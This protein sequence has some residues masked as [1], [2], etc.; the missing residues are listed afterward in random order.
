MANITNLFPGGFT[1]P[2]P[3]HKE[4]PEQ[5]L[6]QAMEIAGMLAPEQIHMDGKIHR[7]SVTGKKKDDSG[8][9]VIYPDK[10]PAGAFGNWKDGT[11]QTWRADIGRDLTIQEEMAHKRRITEARKQQQEEQAKRREVA[12]DTSETIWNGATEA[13]NDHPYLKRK[14]IEAHGIRVTGDGR[15]IVPM[16]VDG[17]LSS[18]QY[19]DGDGGKKFQGG[20][21]TSGACFIVGDPSEKTLVIC[22]GFADAAII[23]QVTGLPALCAFSAHNMPA[24]AKYA[25]TLNPSLV[26]VA[27]ND[28][29]GTGQKYGKQAA[30][31]TNS[32]LVLPPTIGHD[33]NDFYQDGGDL[34]NLIMPPQDD[35]L[36]PADDF[37]S[38]PVSIQWLIKGVIQRNAL[39]MVHGPS[40]G[41]KTFVVIDQV[42]HIAAN[43]PEW[44]GKKIHSGPV[45]YLA[46]EG[47]AG[48]RARLAAWKRHNKADRLNMWLSKAGT[49]LN[50]PEG[51][52]KVRDAINQLPE[53]PAA[54]VVDTLHRFLA[55]DENSAQDAKTMID[56]CGY[57]MQEFN[58]TVLLVHHT[59]VSEDSQHRARGSSAWKG[60]LDLE[61][62][63][64][65]GSESEPLQLIQRKAKDSEL[66]APMAFEIQ[67]HELDWIDEDGEQVKSAVLVPAEQST[68][69]KVDKKAHED[70]R[71]LEKAWWW[72]G[73]E[74]Q[75]SSPYISRSALKRYLVTEQGQKENYAAQQI[76]PSAGKLATRLIDSHYVEEIAQGFAIIDS[77]DAGTL[78][79][80]KRGKK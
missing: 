19:I 45:V 46:G 40:G 17:E 74:V 54:I 6:R 16:Y 37:C 47:H 8:W 67:S 36:I 41:G 51:Y 31:A 53:P 9:Y 13:S 50:T 66:I 76:K 60:A 3:D 52:A 61:F 10:V 58:T 78:I 28:E 35:Y 24:A 12:A 62:S 26:I 79:L 11:N 44:N 48:M 15:L 21:A 49:D 22:E 68:K 70:R 42:C 5:Q 2:R 69:V 71:L 57:L 1:P 30:D 20:G 34:I 25:K 80:A 63:V 33:A 7:F 39:I 65:P 18:L 59:G 75:N 56:A 72:S 73:A 64:V 55:G 32:R 27:D 14:S 23:H 38:Q 29:S 43:K 77:I 4:P